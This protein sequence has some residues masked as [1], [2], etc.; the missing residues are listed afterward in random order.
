MTEQYIMALDQGTTSTR[1]MLFNDQGQAVAT[2]QKELPQ[3]F[4]HPGWVEHDAQV[5]WDDARQVMAEVVIKANIAPYKVAGIGLTNQRETTVIWDRYTGEPI[6]PAVVW[7]SKQSDDIAEELKAAG[8]TD[9]IYQK[10]GLWVD[11]YFSA[12]KIMWL[13]DNVPGARARAERGE[14]LFGTIDTWLLYKLTNGA[15]HATDYS[16]ASR[17]MLFN[18][19]TLTW[20]ADL[21]AKFNIPASLLPEVKDSSGLF[22]YTA[23]YAFFGI[24][25]PIA[26]IAGDQQAALFGHQ[27]FQP[28]EVKNTFGTGSFIVMNTGQNIATSEHGLLTTI[29][30]SIDGQVTYALEGSVFIAGAAIQWLRDGLELIKSAKE[31]AALATLA[32]EQHPE[33]IYL[34]PAFAGLGAPY[35]D[36]NARG[37][38]FGLT[39]ASSK[40]DLVRATLES[41]A[42][43]TRDVLDAMIKDTGLT[44]A[45]LVIDGGAAANDYLQAFQANLINT[46]VRRPAQLETTALGAAYLAGLGVGFWSDL[47]H[48]P[49]P[50]AMELVMPE[51]NQ[52]QAMQS[53]YA[54]WQ[55]AVAATRYFAAQQEK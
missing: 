48:L 46:P 55:K 35:W 18:I 9:Y 10:T 26:G 16:N 20:D 47:D 31:T 4:N 1:A 49:K 28:G 25:V 50:E 27:A 24:Q 51:A 41:L 39:R 21:L 52:Q 33:P 30:Y 6:A 44:M 23:D 19:H 53:A 14:L 37:A 17:T 11:A 5:I 36:Q 15:V 29:G 38:M 22:G 13:L 45:N 42:Y 32:R 7:Q 54:G 3:I 43:Q 40:G 2:A 12:T 34:V 8:L